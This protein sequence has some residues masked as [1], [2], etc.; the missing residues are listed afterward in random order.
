MDAYAAT[1]AILDPR[2]RSRAT[3]ASDD[4]HR[5]QD[6][7]KISVLSERE[8]ALGHLQL[9]AGKQNADPILA[10]LQ[11]LAA[12][13]REVDRST[14]Q[15]MA[16][17]RRFFHRPYT[18]KELAEATGMSQ[19]NVR[20]GFNESDV[21]AVAQTIGQTPYPELALTRTDPDPVDPAAIAG[22]LTRLEPYFDDPTLPARVAELLEARGYRAHVP[23]AREAGK[24][25]TKQYVRWVKRWPDG[26]SSSLYQERGVLSTAPKVTAPGRQFY[27]ECAKDGLAAIEEKLATFDEHM[28]RDA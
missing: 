18:Y 16:Y 19:T 6:D 4:A 21:D 15:L 9:V 25:A 23:E 12:V 26:S 3:P 5:D 7:A 13:R 2:R 28:T 1:A 20:T 24:V 14:R 17:G 11:D 8:R 27:S 22:M 10:A